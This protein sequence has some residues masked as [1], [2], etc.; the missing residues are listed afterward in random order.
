MKLSFSLPSKSSSRPS[1]SSLKFDQNQA[2]K[3]EAAE[4]HY[5]TEF[6]SSKT[7][8]EAPKLIIPPKENTWRHPKK[9]RN[10]D[11]PMDGTSGPSPM[12]FELEDAAAS[13]ADKSDISHGLNLRSRDNSDGDKLPAPESNNSI[14]N[15]MLEKFHQDMKSLPDDRGFEEFEAVPVEGFG[16]ALLAGYGWSE[17]KGIGRNAKEDVKVVQFLRRAN[18]EGLGFV[19]G[20]HDKK[21]KDRNSDSLDTTVLV[22]P[23]GPDGRTRH[24]VGIDEKLVPRELKGIVVGKVVR[25]ISGRHAGLKGKVVEKLNSDSKNSSV[26]LKLVKSEEEVPVGLD[27]VAELGSVQEERYLKKLQEPSVNDKE[28]SDWLDRKKKD[29]QKEAK[30]KGKESSREERR[31]EDSS[32]EQQNGEK[33]DRRNREDERRRERERVD[34]APVTWL[35]SHIRVRVVSKTLKGGKLYLKKGEVMDVVGPRTCDIS[36]DESKELIQGVDQ[37]ILETALP[38]KGGPVLVLFGKHKGIFGNLVERNVDKEIGIIRDA[39]SQALL[40]VRLEQ[41]AEYIGDP[42]YLGY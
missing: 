34:R 26:L 23:K 14:E 4:L 6:D 39:D 5:V 32:R 41:I 22:A 27:E 25:I 35:R 28:S 10:L 21:K 30:S 29:E 11:L 2:A 13:S 15:M 37:D 42:S 33:K 8:T 40:T 9:M 3:D 19:P 18:K 1:K 20:E 7:L 17:G 24:V 12:Q 36:M 16:A 38:K 31:R